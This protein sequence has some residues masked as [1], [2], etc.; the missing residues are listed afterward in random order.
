[1]SPGEHWWEIAQGDAL[2]DGSRWTLVTEE[3]IAALDEK[4]IDA[5]HGGFGERGVGDD[6][7]GWQSFVKAMLSKEGRD[8]LEAPL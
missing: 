2:Q 3:V 7:R 5:D 8:P 1:V 4:L 6:L